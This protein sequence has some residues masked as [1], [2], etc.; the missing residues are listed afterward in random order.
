MPWQLLVQAG[1]RYLR[2]RFR[3]DIVAEGRESL[4][5]WLLHYGPAL[6]KSLV[7]LLAGYAV[8]LVFG[9]LG[10]PYLYRLFRPEITLYVLAPTDGFQVYFLLS[11]VIAVACLIPFA[12]R[13]ALFVYTAVTGRPFRGFRYVLIAFL[14]FVL[15]LYFGLFVF[16]P[17]LFRFT[18]TLSRAF[19]IEPY[20]SVQRYY[21]FMVGLSLPMAFFFETP[22]LMYTLARLGWVKPAVYR[23]Y[24][25]YAYFVLY[26]IAS[27][28][29]PPDVLAHL[30]GAV[31]LILLYEAGIFSTRFIERPASPTTGENS[32]PLS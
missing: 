16:F 27:M 18:L 21:S 29:T 6:R 1:Q 14:L 9:F 2:R 26:V 3:R 5:E 13:E 31:P 17:F 4:A 7:R 23:R 24:R 10:A 15:G 25:K 30:S 32:P 28:I 22:L 20:Y 12:V 8:F 11:N 19:H